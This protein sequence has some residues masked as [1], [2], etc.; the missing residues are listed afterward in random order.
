MVAL[1]HF[2]CRSCRCSVLASTFIMLCTSQKASLVF[3]WPWH[4]QNLNAYA[5]INCDFAYLLRVSA[6]THYEQSQMEFDRKVVICVWYDETRGVA[7][8]MNWDNIFG[9]HMSVLLGIYFIYIAKKYLCFVFLAPPLLSGYC[10][11]SWFRW[12]YLNV[13]IEKFPGELTCP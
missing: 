13:Y 9:Q 6:D 4:V 12:Y 5:I 11:S 7:I 3:S 2:F 8:T 10:V 1:S